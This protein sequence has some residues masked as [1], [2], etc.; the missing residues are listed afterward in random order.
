MFRSRSLLILTA[1]LVGN[2]VAMPAAER[3]TPSAGATIT[4]IGGG[5]GERL[6]RDPTFEAEVQ[7]RFAAQRLMIRNMC[8]DGDT[9][10]FRAHSGRNS[11]F[12]FP[13]AERDSERADGA[14]DRWPGIC[15]QPAFPR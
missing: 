1:G 2:W 12:A 8:D 9:P 13:G 14:S 6:L 3:I 4:L 11:P 10:G 5:Q 15:Q 7:Q